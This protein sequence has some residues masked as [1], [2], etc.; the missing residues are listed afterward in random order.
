M[1]STFFLEYL[2][3]GGLLVSMP[4]LSLLWSL[5]LP[6]SM[7]LVGL[8]LLKRLFDGRRGRVGRAKCR[9]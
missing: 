3:G 4:L 5:L 8:F 7:L 6:L 2:G 1:I 9:I